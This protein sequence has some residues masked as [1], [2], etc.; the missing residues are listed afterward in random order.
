LILFLLKE[1]DRYGKKDA[2]EEEIRNAAQRAG[3]LKFIENNE[4]EFM[5]ENEHVQ[6]EGFKTLINSGSKQSELSTSQKQKIAIARSIIK[7]P[8]VMV[9]DDVQNEEILDQIVT[10]NTSIILS[11][12]ISVLGR[13]ED[14]LVFS[15]GRLVERGSYENLKAQQGVIFGLEKDLILN[16]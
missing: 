5:G 3:A 11:N 10:G 8:A 1:F 16:L 6:R 15:Q 13:T 7:N 2:S 4:F 14:I 12:K 9:L